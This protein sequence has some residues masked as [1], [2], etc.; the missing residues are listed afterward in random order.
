MSINA[1]TKHESTPLLENNDPPSKSEV[2]EE[3]MHEHRKLQKRIEQEDS[4][5][6]RISIVELVAMSMFWFGISAHW[7]A[8]L[9]IVMPYQVARFAP[10][11]H[12][13]TILGVVLL[14]G[15]ATA[16]VV[17]VVFGHISDQC[18]LRYGKRRP[19]IIAGTL[20]NVLA[21]FWCAYSK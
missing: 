6:Q 4:T 14:L 12:K 10:D 21:L 16:M 2:R 20:G 15:S 17:S 13:N 9:M 19:F 11:T 18:L 1:P 5:H 3:A 7:T 8:I